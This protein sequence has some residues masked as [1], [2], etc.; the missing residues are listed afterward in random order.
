MRRYELT[1]Q[2]TGGIQRINLT[3]DNNMH[4]NQ[5]EFICTKNM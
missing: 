5:N 2:T 3:L 4:V 1:L